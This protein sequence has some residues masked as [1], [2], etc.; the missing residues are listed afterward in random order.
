MHNA[1]PPPPPPPEAWINK[2]MH[3]ILRGSIVQLRAHAPDSSLSPCSHVCE[4]TFIWIIINAQCT[5]PPETFIQTSLFS[6]WWAM[7]TSSNR[8]IF[9]G[10]GPLYGEFT[11]HRWISLTQAGDAELWYLLWS[12][13]EPTIEYTIEKPVIWDAVVLI[14]ASL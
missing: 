8:N 14:M 13:T 4:Y 3:C 11:G 6:S 1:P 2:D 12:A 5:P 10:P 7:M 9:G